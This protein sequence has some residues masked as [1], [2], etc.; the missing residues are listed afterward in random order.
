M[1]IPY[2]EKPPPG[3]LEKILSKFEELSTTVS[4]ARGLIYKCRHI[5]RLEGC[6]NED[7]KLRG[8]GKPLLLQSRLEDG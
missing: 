2:G 5:N 6:I 4:F 3:V 8:D 1:R 7:V